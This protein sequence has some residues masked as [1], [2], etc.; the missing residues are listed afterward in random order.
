MEADFP[1]IRPKSFLPHQPKQYPQIQCL[2]SPKISNNIPLSHL[3]IS[4]AQKNPLPKRS[5]MPELPEIVVF[6]RQM[7]RV[8]PGKTIQT[9]EASQPKSLNLPREK[10]HK[11][12]QGERVIRIQP[13]GKWLDIGLENRHL[14]ISLGMGGEILYHRPGDEP[15]TKRHCLLTLDDKSCVSV[16]FWWFGYLHLV[17]EVAQHPTV[18]ELGQDPLSPE[19]KVEALQELVAARRGAIKSLLLDQR[20]IAGIGN[21]YIQEILFRARLHPLRPAG[22]LR[23]EEICSLHQGIQSVLNESISKGSSEFELDF[24]GHKGTYGV[25]DMSVGYKLGEPCPVC[26]M[27]VEKIKTGGTAQYICPQCQSLDSKK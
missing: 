27:P 5:P 23:G 11:R 3:R 2:N 24:F 13:L 26:G 19:F 16:K 12:L 18:G 4:A 25:R 10:F 21:F 17:K 20:I 9:A 6:A 22:S 1:K 15:P 7:N 8:L 14:L